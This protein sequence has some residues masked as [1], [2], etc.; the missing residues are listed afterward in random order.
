[1]YRWL[2]AVSLKA[3]IASFRMSTVIRN[4]WTVINARHLSKMFFIAGKV[5]QRSIPISHLTRVDIFFYVAK[6]IRSIL[7]LRNELMNA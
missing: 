2:F 4:I 3:F 1:M 6:L 7:I 5:Q